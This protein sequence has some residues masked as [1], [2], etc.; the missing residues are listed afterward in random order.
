MEKKP[1][2]LPEHDSRAPSTLEEI[3]TSQ[4]L[5][6][7]V[8][9]PSLDLVLIARPAPA[10]EVLEVHDEFESLF[11]EIGPQ[12]LFDASRA[13]LKP[14]TSRT[15]KDM[16]LV[17]F[18]NEKLAPYHL[19]MMALVLHSVDGRLSREDVELLIARMGTAEEVMSLME[20]VAPYYTADVNFCSIS[21]PSEQP[22]EHGSSWE[23]HSGMEASTSGPSTNYDSS[24]PTGRG[25]RSSS[26]GGSNG[27]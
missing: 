19:A 20:V 4:R 24:R 16:E 5:A 12:R 25:E 22:S 17:R 27:Y 9:I 21:Q 14:A 26:G 10:S 15:D 7:K 2:E 13:Q 18:V 8:H 3:R 23:Y 11:N 6:V 1:H